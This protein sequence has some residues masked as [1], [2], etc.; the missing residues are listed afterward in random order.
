MAW[1]VLIIL[2]A[3]QLAKTIVALL[4]ILFGNPAVSV[5]TDLQLVIGYFL[6]LWW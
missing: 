5:M 6:V 1:H 4:L 3:S 2:I